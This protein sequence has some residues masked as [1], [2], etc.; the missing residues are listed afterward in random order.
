LEL[1]GITERI[2]N[3]KAKEIYSLI[4][5][6]GIVSK[7][8]LLDQSGMAVSTLTRLL[9]ELT[10]QGLILESGYGASTGGRRPI[11]YQMNP[12]YAYV[13]GLEI[14]RTLSKLVL[15]DLEM[16]KLDTHSWPMTAD[17]TPDELIKLVA[18]EVSAMMK[19]HHVAS[20]SVLG[21]GIGAVGP[22]ERISGI[23]LEPL[24]FPAPGW[25][26]V[27]ICDR[28]RDLTGMPVLL[29]NGAN[30]A[31][32]A[33]SWLNRAQSYKH[34]LYIHIG[35]GLRSSMLSEGKVIYGAVDM[36]G[37]VGQMIIQTDGVAHRSS[38]GNY[39]AL[40][41]Y[42]SIYA[43][44]QAA[45]SAMKQGRATVLWETV[46]NPDRVAFSHIVEALQKNDPLS[47]EIVTEAATYFG[48][49]LANL[50]NILHPEKVILGGPLLAG[51]ELFFQ[52]ATQVAIR[53]TYYYPSYQV[54][55]S[56]GNLGE[57]ALAIGAAVMVMGHLTD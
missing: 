15:I 6:K 26:N 18:D 53:K 45:R 35:I 36:E 38:S 51:S 1:N 19:R 21:L 50:L 41:S 49:G 9:E 4:R 40:E 17:M 46:Q 43:I 14:S 42:A 11:L 47:V 16:N 5:R 57:E 10:D 32:L 27:N 44:E 20:A 37:S 30:T 52:V 33:E 29:E 23:I 39:G 48:I 28:L 22:I 8:D 56:K 25:G 24:Y 13:F 34:L 7:I 55:F 31:L 2:S 12:T 3:R 54:V